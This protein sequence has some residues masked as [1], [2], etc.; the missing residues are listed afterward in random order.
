LL[1][2]DPYGQFTGGCLYY[3]MENRLPADVW[4]FC[5]NDE[6]IN[7]VL[8]AFSPTQPAPPEGASDAHAAL[9]ARADTFCQGQYGYLNDI[10]NKVGDAI[11][12]FSGEASDQNLAALVTEIEQ[13]IKNLEDTLEGI[14]AFR[15][16]E[17]DVETFNT[18]VDD[19]SAQVDALTQAK[20]ALA[21]RDLDGYDDFGTEFNDLSKDARQ[22]A[23]DYGFA[24]CSASDFG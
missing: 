5:F 1:I 10:T 8:T 14:A 22:A 3:G 18:Y 13:F 12:D 20:D 19:L 23:R 17:D 24:T 9:L 16:P 11:L 6:G 21:E 4:Q 15:A 2:Q 7:V